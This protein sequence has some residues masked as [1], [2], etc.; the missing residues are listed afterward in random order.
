VP[1]TSWTPRF[2][3]TEPDDFYKDLPQL[4]PGNFEVT[5]PASDPDDLI[6]AHNCFAFAVGDKRR[7]WWPEGHG[8]W[9]PDCER[10]ATVESLLSALKTKG[11]TECTGG[12]FECG[13]EKVAIYA[14]GGVAG[15][16]THVALQFASRN[17]KW[18]SK[19]GLNVDIEHDL[20][21]LNGPVYGAPVKFASRATSR[22]VVAQ[23][24]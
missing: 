14:K 20:D 22:R 12:A 5:S 4:K 11:F 13:V 17:G 15:V 10:K 2:P 18:R 3:I 19:I 24:G 23:V 7:W 8:Y 9:P 6:R 16:A 1:S 21:Q